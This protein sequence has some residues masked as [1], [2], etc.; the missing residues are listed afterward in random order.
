MTLL[1]LYNSFR[2]ET[3]VIDQMMLDILH[4]LVPFLLYLFYIAYTKKIDDRENELFLVCMTFTALYIVLKYNKPI[5]EFIP[6]FLVN[7][8]LL[9]SYVKRNNITIIISS[10]VAI[11]YYYN[12]YQGYL[13][14]IVIIYMLYYILYKLLFKVVKV[15]SFL[16]LFT[17]I[18]VFC[19]GIF[20]A[21]LENNLILYY[22]ELGL[23]GLLFWF[24]SWVI[25]YMLIQV[26][27][28]LKIKVSAKEI[29]HDK[30]LK[31]TLFHLAHEIKNPIAVC[32]GY[33]DMIDPEN[34]E[35]TAKYVS[36]MKEEVHKTF[37]VLEDFLSMNKIKLNKD[38]LDINYLLSDFVKNYE[39]YF[40][41]N[42]IKTDIKITDDEVF[43]NGDYNKLFQVLL[44]IIKNSVEALNNNPKIKI[45]T[46]TKK[47]NFS[48]NIE[49]NGVGIAD[50]ALKKMGEPF[51]TTK[52]NGTG[53]GVSLSMGIIEAHEGNL[54]Y[55]SEKGKYTRA[56]I[57]LPIID[58]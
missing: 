47:N 56:I 33:L 28:I 49:D 1:I 19:I 23:D 12:F 21:P 35:Q 46:T 29:E 58:I 13:F 36:I 14:F 5:F 50:E 22:F 17:L 10:L 34:I 51:F 16:A 18:L 38:I 57:T 8:P 25:I 26:E 37:I 55:E 15:Q 48:I 42:K 40:K 30:K 54:V 41:A 9:V 27:D 43:I 6:M 32:K 20:S 31:T 52:I 7:I 24:I 11:L 39:P 2:G 53:L 44:N 4:V 3:M 45:W